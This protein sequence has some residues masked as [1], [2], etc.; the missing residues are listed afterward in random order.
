MTTWP[1]PVLAG[2]ELDAVRA[3]HRPVVERRSPEHLERVARRVVER[4][5]SRRPGAAP[6]RRRARLGGHAGRVQRLPRSRRGPPR[7]RPPS[8]RPAAGRS[9]PARSRTA[10]GSRPSAGRPRPARARGPRSCRAAWCRSR[11]TRPGRSPR[12]AGTQATGSRSSLTC[13]LPE[14]RK[15]SARRLNS[16]NFSSCAQCPQPL[17]TCSCALRICLSATSAPSSG[18]TR[19]S[20]PQISSTSLRSRC[21]SR[22]SMPSS[23]VAGS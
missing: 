11:A 6:A 15:S 7:W 17:K 1:M 21:T 5:S 20:R 12:S 22:Q 9:R 13:L 23:A 3:E 19:S 8:P 18:L 16:S 10:R 2:H 14:P 4:R